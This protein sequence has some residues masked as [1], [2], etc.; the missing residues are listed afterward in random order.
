MSR[1]LAL[2]TVTGRRRQGAP[3]RAMSVRSTTLVDWLPAIDWRDFR[4][5]D[6]RVEGMP[7]QLPRAAMA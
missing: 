7:F 6:V 4:R 3:H 2:R 5:G 1:T